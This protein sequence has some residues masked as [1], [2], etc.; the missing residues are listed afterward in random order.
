MK[1]E[2]ILIFESYL[3]AWVKIAYAFSQYSYSETPYHIQSFCMHMS[4]NQCNAMYQFR[5]SCEL[6]ARYCA[7]NIG[8]QN[9][10]I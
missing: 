1:P 6:S 9:R 7:C 4:I 2:M 8:V 5:H 10:Q 3:L